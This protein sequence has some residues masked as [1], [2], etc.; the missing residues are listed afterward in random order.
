MWPFSLLNHTQ[1]HSA[2]LHVISVVLAVGQRGP[3]VHF[4]LPAT[5]LS[6]AV[7]NPKYKLVSDVLFLEI[8]YLLLQGIPSV[9][10]PLLAGANLN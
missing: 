1:C 10:T 5:D 9:L 8:S 7:R 4:W 2:Q 6:T 3:L